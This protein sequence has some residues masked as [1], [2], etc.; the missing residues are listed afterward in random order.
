MREDVELMR[1]IPCKD[2]TV[3]VRTVS[4]ALLWLDQRQ[5]FAPHWSRTRKC[6]LDAKVKR[7]LRARRNATR[8]FQEAMEKYR[9]AAASEPASRR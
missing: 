1:A 3:L 5:C 6:L 2:S 7:S 4:D 8:A 9:Q